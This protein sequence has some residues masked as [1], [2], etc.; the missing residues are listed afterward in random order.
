MY[1]NKLRW[2]CRKGIRELDILLE[3]FLELEFET[4]SKQNKIYFEELLDFDTYDLLNAIFGKY[5][6][7]NKYT[8][9]INKL[10]NLS[11]NNKK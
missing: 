3:E 4:L 7:D 5:T 6:Y 1:Q 10:S 9:L 11:S 8:T 2:K